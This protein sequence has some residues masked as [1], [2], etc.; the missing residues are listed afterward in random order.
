MVT[1]LFTCAGGELA[2]FLISL[3]RGSSR[4]R[5]RVVAVDGRED[6]AG[7]A[8]ADA[9]H[10][11]PYGSAPDYVDAIVDIVR[12]EKV[13]LVLPTSDEEAVALSAA[14]ARIAEAGAEL[15]CTDHDT[16]KLFS[17]KAATYQRLASEGLHVPDW[18]CCTGRDAAVI[19]IDDLLAAHGE[20]VV[21]PAKARGGRG[22]SVIRKDVAGAS[23]EFGGRELHIDRETFLNTE[24]T[25]LPEQDAIIVMERLVAP[26]LDID[27]LAWQG[28]P[29]R[30][31]P[32]RRV[33]TA[34]PNEGHV[35]IDAPELRALGEKLVEIFKLTWLYDCDVMLDR[36]GRPNV[37]EINPRPSGSVSAS[38]AAGVP[39]I[40]DMIS[41]MQGQPVPP[42]TPP[43]G[44]VVVPIKALAIAGRPL[45]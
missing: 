24:L 14:R 9:F 31:V 19:A 33:N 4:H 22:V 39:L 42:M 29:I 21:K 34:L 15:A 5:I 25:R 27:M 6:A 26:V 41:L 38:I 11:V 45:P 3:I 43:Y 30:V 10:K 23:T 18:R 16:L 36:D 28:R 12:R 13:T 2:P 37:L 7:R 40:D 1:L 17:D 8:I 32:R 35:L 20:C 44:R